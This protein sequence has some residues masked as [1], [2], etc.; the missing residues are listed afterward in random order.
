[1]RYAD[2]PRVE[3]EVRVAAPAKTV[4]ELVTDI[5]LPAR[6]GPE[7]QRVAWLDGAQGPCSGARF[8]GFN[9][10]PLIGEWRTVSHVVELAEPEVFAW[11]VTDA[12]G[13]YGAPSADPAERLATWRYELNS[14]DGGRETLLRQSAVLGPGRSG[15]TLAVERRPDREEEIIAARLKELR[16]GME[17]TLDGIRQLAERAER[18]R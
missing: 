8:E 15:V 14:R 16:A 13:R 12:D 10:H 9:Q 2:G 1:M 18:S 17:A 11:A 7:L 4:W 3:C 5:R 6:F